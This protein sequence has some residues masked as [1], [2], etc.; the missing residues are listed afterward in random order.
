MQMEHQTAKRSNVL[1]NKNFALLFGGVLVSNIAHILFNFAMSL[2]VL[3]IAVEAYGQDKAP[4]IQGYFLLTA[5]LTLVILMPI[6]GVFADRLNKVKTM[7]ITDFF[8][9]ITILATGAALYYSPDAGQKLIFLFIMAVILGINSAF[10]SPASA[11]LLKFIVKE[12]E[13]Q[14]ASSY[15][16]GSR[17]LQSIL[18]LILGGIL[19]ASFGIY[20]LFILNGIAYIISAISEI[21]IRY[22][23][24]VNTEN[25]TVKVIM[26]EIGEGIKYVLNFRALFVLVMMALFLNFFIAPIYENGMPYFIEFGLA[27]EQSFLFDSFMSVENWFS[28]ILIVGSISGI[29]MSIVLSTRKPKDYYH[30]DINSSLIAF[31]VM[32]SLMAIAMSL[33]HLGYIGI[34]VTLVSITILLF[35]MGFTQVAFN[36][37]VSVIIQ[38]KVDGD[39]LGKVQSVLNVLAQAF[40]PISALVGGILISKISITAFYAFNA[41]GMLLTVIVYVS[42]KYARSI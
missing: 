12:E 34:N 4:M 29:V 6:G 36:V 5:G 1:R 39:H 31:V 20:I 22:D 13:L 21:F 25:T 38:T 3:R 26:N 11:S 42:N 16:H 8:R 9:G 37:P 28:V 35:L 15:L 33:Y 41:L 24:K 7:Y 18:G 17:N 27:K 14:Q 40:I 10:F 30:K 23:A 32:C 2:Y 19:Y